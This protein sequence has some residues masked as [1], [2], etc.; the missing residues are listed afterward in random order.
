[1]G[2]F[3]LGP[4][5]A[6]LAAAALLACQLVAH[7]QTPSNPVPLAEQPRTTAGIPGFQP[8][9][10]E[11]ADAFM[12]HQ[13]YQAAIEA[14]KKAPLG[15][16]SVWNKMGIAYQMMYNLGDAARCY[17]ASLKIDPKNARVLNNLATLYDSQKDYRSAEQMYRKA[18]RIEPKSALVLKNF[19]T[20]QLAQHRYKKGW[21]LYQ[22]AIAIDPVIFQDHGTPRVNNPSSVQERGAMNYYMARGCVRAGQS[23]CAIEYLRMAMNEGFITPK[24]IADDAEFSSLRDLPAFKQLLAA[25]NTP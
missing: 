7:A 14:Y 5:L 11:A 20:N 21:E 9:P 3:M 22:S 10:E 1:M 19:G 25:Q 8:T 6:S 16:P 17:R 18:I 23:D 15:S 13:R 12:T 2:G 24:K 4:R